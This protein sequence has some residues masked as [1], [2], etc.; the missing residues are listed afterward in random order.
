MSG[1][2]KKNTGFLFLILRYGRQTADPPD[3]ECA[4]NILLYRRENKEYKNDID[5]KEKIDRCE[6]E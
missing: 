1:E 3:G 2:Y 4:A 6:R 5:R